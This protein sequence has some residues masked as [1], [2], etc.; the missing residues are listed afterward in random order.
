MALKVPLYPKS[1]YAAIDHSRLALQKSRL[2]LK[3]E[4]L[5]LQ[6][7][8]NRLKSVL[9]MLEA[10]VKLYKDSVADKKRLLKIAKVAY[11]S[12]RM[13]TE[14]YLKYEDDLVTQEAKLHEAEAK[15]WQTLMQ[16][17]V[18]YTNPIEE[19]VQ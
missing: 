8:A 16:L 9:P 7:Q 15:K 5:S 11:Q 10:S 17:A 19:I 14:D 3:K 13:S 6:A 1:Q 18:I 4:E 12:Q 2:E